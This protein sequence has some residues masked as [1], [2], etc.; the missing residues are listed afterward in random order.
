MSTQT[1]TRERGGC[2]TIYL[3]LIV[4]GSILGLASAF[5]LNATMQ[6]LQAQGADVPSIPSWYAPATILPVL[7]SLVGAYG[8]WTWKKWGVYALA[9]TIALNVIFSILAGQV[10]T[11][12]AA[13]V[14][15]GGLLWFVL[16]N[17]MSL[18]E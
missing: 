9:G 15:G 5:S 10:V 17:K 16:R 4:I 8:T 11:G 2:L 18:F 1:G 12:I 14:I 6:Q 3:I 13:L 7:L